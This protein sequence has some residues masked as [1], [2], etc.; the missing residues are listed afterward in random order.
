MDIGNLRQH[1]TYEHQLTTPSGEKL[2]V[3]FTLAGPSHPARQAYQNRAYRQ[4]SREFNKKGKAALPED[5]D[6][7]QQQLID[8]MVACTL[9]WN[10]LVLDGKTL[11]F[12]STAA[13]ALFSNPEFS[14][15]LDDIAGGADKLENFMPSSSAT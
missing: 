13:R 4:I 6:E 10:N 11:E 1:D 8:R 15:V 3:Y 5:R 9:G 2:D 7:V 12:S 14:W